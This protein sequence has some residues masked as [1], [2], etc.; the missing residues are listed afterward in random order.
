MCMT[1]DR[2]ARDR[3]FEQPATARRRGSR[4]TAGQTRAGQ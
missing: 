3:P 1:E 2:V 4:V